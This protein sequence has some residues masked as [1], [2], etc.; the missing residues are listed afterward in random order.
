MAGFIHRNDALKEMKNGK[1]FSVTVVTCDESRKRGGS[2]EEFT[3]VK[4]HGVD[5]KNHN[6][7]VRFPGGQIREF[8]IWLIIYFNDQKVF[9]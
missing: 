4:L 6:R 5:Y 2:I 1:P 7:E 3:N 9:L 8:N